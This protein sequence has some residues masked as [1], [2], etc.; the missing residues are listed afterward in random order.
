MTKLKSWFV[1][2]SFSCIAIGGSAGELLHK[3]PSPQSYRQEKPPTGVQEVHYPA[4]PGQLM[5]WFAMPIK[6]ERRPVPL[7]VYA[8]GGF[9]FGADDFA[10]TEP[11]RSAG[12]AVL[13]PTFRGEN[14]NPG[15][16]ELMGGEVDD[17]LAA[18]EWGRQQAGVDSERVYVFGH[19]VG[20]NLSGLVALQDSA[21]LRLAGAASGAYPEQIFEAWQ[22]IVPF[23]AKKPLEKQRRLYPGQLSALS[24][25][26]F[27]YLGT[28]EE[29]TPQIE[30]WIKSRAKSAKQP[31][32]IQLV[33]GD[34]EGMLANAAQAFSE[35]IRRDAFSAK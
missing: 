32:R 23:D 34:H 19:S 2:F 21:K 11:F 3:G 13:T 24:V 28:G 35:V 25:P 20:G 26:F 12:F 7:L 4:A 33:P 29:S 16:F 30:P 18:I 9:A 1:A 10:A 17:L 6:P 5:A 31:F 27:L 14:G 8:H 22:R 15:Y